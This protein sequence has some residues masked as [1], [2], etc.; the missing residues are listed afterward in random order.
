MCVNNLLERYWKPVY[1]YL[2]RKGYGNEQAKDLTQGFF[3][4]IALGRELF[5]QAD[6]SKGR[7]RTFLLTA[8]D[9]YVTSV[10]RSETARKRAPRDGLTPLDVTEIPETAITQSNTSPEQA[11]YRTWVANLL[12]QV[13]AQVRDE[14]CSTGREAYWRVFYARILAPILEDSDATPYRDLCRDC[15]IATK[16]KARNMLITVKRRFATVLMGHLRQHV[17]SDAEVEEELGEL[18]K[19]FSEGGAA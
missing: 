3:C 11:F 2:R 5:Q 4:E 17:R 16:R 14:Y 8:L 9:R 15:G 1:C 7:F 13:V 10:Y 6:E 19:I 18:I 12:E